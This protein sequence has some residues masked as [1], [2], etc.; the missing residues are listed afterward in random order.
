MIRF[1]YTGPSAAGP[2][3]GTLLGGGGAAGADPDPLTRLAG[4]PGSPGML[5]GEVEEGRAGVALK[6]VPRSRTVG[7]VAAGALVPH[8]SP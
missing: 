4:A 2:G 8:R 7:E 6:E 5:A 3:N 1:A